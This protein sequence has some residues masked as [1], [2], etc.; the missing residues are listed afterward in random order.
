MRVSARL[1]RASAT[2][3]ATVTAVLVAGVPALP[4]AADPSPG[5]VR[6]RLVKLNEQ[7]DQLVERFNQATETYR[8]ARTA[9]RALDA[10]LAREG[11]RVTELRSELAAIAAHDYRYGEPLNWQRLVVG[12]DPE[13]MLSRMAVLDQLARDRAAR[14]AAFEQ[15][16]KG[17]RTRRD[18]AKDAL[19]RAGRARDDV[20][21]RKAKVDKLVGEQ[22]RLLRELGDYRA[23]NPRSAG[24]AYTGPASG[25]A[26]RALT[27]AFAQIG[28]PYRYGGT[29]PA[30]F[31][32]SGLAQAAWRAAG[33]TLP[34]TT[35][36]QWSWG[37][38]RRVDL[39]AVKPGD[40]LFSRGL[41]HM[42]IYAGGGKMVH[43]PQTGDVVK[44]VDLDDYWRGRLV[45]AVRP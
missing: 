2:V 4:A 42:G 13:T 44:V 40:L 38:G 32:C 21:G 10:E 33:V 22:T 41:G 28:K 5:Q 34:R 36:T 11:E 37:A 14:I 18:Q 26:R 29:G 23:G 35:Y 17:L 7:A 9:Y 31:D 8:E 30:S 43:A 19:D 20:R 3:T 15:A 16:T 27:F 39:D 12:G 45:G 6:A 1:V 25:N 24:V